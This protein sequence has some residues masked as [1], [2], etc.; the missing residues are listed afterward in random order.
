MLPF[1]LT[2]DTPYLALSGELWS[3]FYEYLNRNWSC[4]K[5]FLLY[6]ENIVCKMAAMLPSNYM[7]SILWDVITCPCPWYTTF[8][9]ILTGLVCGLKSLRHDVQDGLVFNVHGADFRDKFQCCFH[10]I[11]WHNLPIS[12]NTVFINKL[13]YEW[14]K[15]DADK[16]FSVRHMWFSSLA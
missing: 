3:V 15:A 8:I 2:K 11:S 5:G 16:K 9:N 10:G 12:D 14:V 7:L 13:K 6:Y 1:E 4:Y